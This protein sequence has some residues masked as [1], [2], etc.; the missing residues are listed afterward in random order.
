MKKLKTAKLSVYYVD[1]TRTKFFVHRATMVVPAHHGSVAK[2]SP[3]N[4]DSAGGIIRF[5]Q[6]TLKCPT[7]DVELYFE[8]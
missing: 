3:Q 8:A 5:T 4:E 2:T 7:L 1:K 6:A